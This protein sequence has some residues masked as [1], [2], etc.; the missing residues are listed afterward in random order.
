[1]CAG[2]QSC[3]FFLYTEK[4][5]FLSQMLFS[6]E[7]GCEILPLKTEVQCQPKKQEQTHLFFQFSSRTL[8]EES[9]VNILVRQIIFTLVQQPVF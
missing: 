2:K 9:L 4:D 1:M 5:I 7:K 8:F 6:L 3:C